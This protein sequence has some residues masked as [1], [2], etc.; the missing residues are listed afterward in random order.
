MRAVPLLVALVLTG[1]AQPAPGDANVTISADRPDTSFGAVA[2]GPIA[3]PD[4]N[5]TTAQPPRLVAGEWWRIQFKSGLFADLDAP[6][7][8]RVVSEAGPNGYVM[9]MPHEG[10]F[11]E[12]IVFHAPA[13]GDVGRDL[14]YDVHNQR[15]MPLKFPLVTGETWVT[16]FGGDNYTA[17]VERADNA[18][19]TIRYDPPASD[20]Q[21]T[22][23]LLAL[24]SP[25]STSG[26][27]R[28]TYDARQHEVVHFEAPF[29]AWDVVAHGYGFTGW[30]TVPRAER[31]AIDYGQFLPATPGAP[32]LTRSVSIP[33]GYNR[34][35]L[36][37]AVAAIGPGVYRVRD[38]SPN[39]T[40]YATE[41]T[42]TRGLTVRFHEASAPGGIWTL[43]DVVG[44]IGATY[45][46]GMAYHQYDVR[47]PDGAIRA[48]H[49]H[50]VIR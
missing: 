48:D 2:T 5:A 31:T 45:T 23:P 28:M 14:S 40:Q 24:L 10:W 37:Q 18:T 41:S 43:E 39:G 13:F 19:A 49:S 15:F 8:V 6:D 12:A 4:L 7:V 35:T 29:G 42:A 47:L 36:L 9:G 17:T 20:P 38:V 22:D 44:G 25:V 26:T 50:P 46:M 32:L 34:M 33:T 21:P 16:P 3:G 11:K 1:C 30:T 27:M